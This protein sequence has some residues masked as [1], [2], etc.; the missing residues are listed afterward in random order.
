MSMTHRDAAAK[1]FYDTFLGLGIPTNSARLTK[2]F[3]DHTREFIQFSDLDDDQKSDLATS[4]YSYLKV[5]QTPTIDTAHF[6]QTYL[7]NDLRD[8]YQ[9]HMRKRSFPATAVSKDISELT[10]VLKRRKITFSRDIRLIAPPDAFNELVDVQ[11]VDA[12]TDVGPRKWTQ[13]TIRDWIRALT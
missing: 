10:G 7:P 6:S 1:Y 9:Q 11:T 12:T 8:A 5:D 13:I 4:L 2:N 3:Y